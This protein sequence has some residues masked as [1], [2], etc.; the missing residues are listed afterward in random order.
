MAVSDDLAFVGAARQAEM[1]RAGEV[2][3]RELVQGLMPTV[4]TRG[5]LRSAVEALRDR[6]AVP[7]DADVE[8]GR[9][10]ALVHGRTGHRDDARHQSR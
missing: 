8:D 5:G 9:M 4:L 6:V 3:P 1:V 2:S 7:V 10:P